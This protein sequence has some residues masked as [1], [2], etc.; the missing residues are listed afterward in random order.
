MSRRRISRKLSSIKLIHKHLKST[1]GKEAEEIP[2]LYGGSVN[3]SNCGAYLTIPGVNGLLVGG[4]SLIA[5]QFNDIIDIAK[6]VAD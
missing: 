3:P 5:D 4:S 1:F 2:V 6:K